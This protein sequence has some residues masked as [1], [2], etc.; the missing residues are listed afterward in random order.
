MNQGADL[1]DRLPAQSAVSSQLRGA[2]GA[3]GINSVANDAVL[4]ISLRALSNRRCPRSFLR[5][6]DSWNR[7]K[8]YRNDLHA[9]LANRAGA[10]TFF[11]HDG[12][13]ALA[14][15]RFFRGC[16]RIGQR[17]QAAELDLFS[18]ASILPRLYWTD[19]CRA[20]PG[21]ENGRLKTRLRR[22]RG[23]FSSRSQKGL[24]ASCPWCSPSP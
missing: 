1:L 6:E 13:K 21:G 17:V 14:A 23:I 15:V 22:C 8:R 4:R 11:T 7:K 20:M 3:P 12:S 16:R 2:L 9:A 5:R 10:A 19:Q 18:R 24:A